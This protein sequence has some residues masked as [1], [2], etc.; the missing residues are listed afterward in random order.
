MTPP[1]N[2]EQLRSAGPFKELLAMLRPNRLPSRTSPELLDE[3]E[4]S[5][6]HLFPDGNPSED[7]SAE[8]D[9]LVRLRQEEIEWQLRYRRRLQIVGLLGATAWLAVGVTLAW[10]RLMV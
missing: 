5:L 3:H 8:Y 10:E 7:G 9:R 6:R 2:H 4:N 1:V